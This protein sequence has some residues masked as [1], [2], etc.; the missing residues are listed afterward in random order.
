M[1]G[2]IKPLTRCVSQHQITSSPITVFRQ[3]LQKRLAQFPLTW[4]HLLSQHSAA[5][6][7]KPLGNER[8]QAKLIKGVKSIHR[9][10]AAQTL[11]FP[12]KRVG[13]GLK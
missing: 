13:H 5:C 4:I 10:L 12:R 6:S 8:M 7:L 11:I 2:I 9:V 1:H 3:L